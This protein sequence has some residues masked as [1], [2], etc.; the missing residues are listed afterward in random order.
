MVW[1]ILEFAAG[2]VLAAVTIADVFSSI[3]VPGP[4]NSALRIASRIRRLTL[5]V[6][7]WMSRRQS[8]GRQRLSNS[9]APLLFSFAFIGWIVL[10]LLGFALML[11]ASAASF[12]PRLRG[13]GDAAYVSGA[14]LLTIGTNLTEPQ[15]YARWL[16]LISA[17][18]GFGVITATITFILEIQSNL[19]EREAGVLRLSGL[20]GKPPSGLG[21]LETYAQLGMRGELGSFFREWAAW[22][23]AT[24]NSHVSFPVL[25]YFHSVDAESDWVTALQ[26]VLDA[27]TLVMTLTNEECGAA[28]LLHR[29]GSRTAAHIC[30][31]FNLDADVA[32][33]VGE[34]EVRFLCEKLTDAGYRLRAVDAEISQRFSD[35]R[36]DYAGRLSAL[37]EHLG[38]QPCPLVPKADST[39]S[40][41]TPKTAAD[42]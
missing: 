5:P 29:S 21:L 2:F 40:T 38:S 32:P 26:V 30:Q 27:A 1:T 10:L 23:A 33:A 12:T 34:E 31:L 9:F 25:I 14:Y 13:F 22:S 41:A 42:A 39:W 24:L 6:W 18:S 17:L 3:L 16:L 28:V 36:A 11:H 37:A 19:H 35:L 15:G 8:G 4:A 7:R 20:V